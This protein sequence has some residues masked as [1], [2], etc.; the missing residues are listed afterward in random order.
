M[1][2]FLATYRPEVR[3]IFCSSRTGSKGTSHSNLPLLVLAVE[4]DRAPKLDVGV[5]QLADLDSVK[6]RSTTPCLPPNLRSQ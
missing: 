5:D 1:R 3:L 2:P 4:L 6:T